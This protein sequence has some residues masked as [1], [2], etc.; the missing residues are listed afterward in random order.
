VN[1]YSLG[2]SGTESDLVYSFGIVP[3]YAFGDE[4][5]YGHVFGGITATTGFQNQGFTNTQQSGS[6]V[7]TFWPFWI[8]SAGYAGSIDML[9]LSAMIYKPVTDESSPV[10]YGLGFIFTVGLAIP[11]WDPRHTDYSEPPPPPSE[12]PP[13]SSEPVSPSSEPASSSSEPASSS[14]EPA[15]SSSE[16][17]SSRSEPVR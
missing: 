11:A 15:S 2:T 10:N 8:F 5:Q 1:S 17:V 3:S 14:S 6:S 7:S 12:P 13:P 16:A 9:R 4:G